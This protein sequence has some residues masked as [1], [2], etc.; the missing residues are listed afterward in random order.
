[1]SPHPV[2]PT[3]LKSAVGHFELQNGLVDTSPIFLP[4]G[5]V[6]TSANVLRWGL[7][8]TNAT[9]QNGVGKVVAL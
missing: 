8:G 2:R 5:L 6:D 3:P 4:T 9:V 1:M 7:V